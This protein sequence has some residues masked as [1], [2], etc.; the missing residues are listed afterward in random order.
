MALMVA[1]ALLTSAGGAQESACVAPVLP[2]VER[3][4]KPARPAVPGC[5]DEAR[6]RHT[7]SNRIIAAYNAEMDRYG[8]AFTA[9]V[10]EINAYSRK[11]GA[12]VEAASDYVQCEQ[13][14]VVPSVLIEG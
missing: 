1:L 8:Q 11:L 14:I 2:S 10:A 3:P 5:V 6:S 7:C 12:Y 13:S 9:Y 4:L